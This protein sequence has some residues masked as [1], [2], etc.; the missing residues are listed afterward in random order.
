MLH[1]VVHLSGWKYQISTRKSNS[2]TANFHLTRSVPQLIYISCSS[3]CQIVD[4]TMQFIVEFSENFCNSL[5]E[6]R[7]Q[8][9][10]AH[11][12]NKHLPRV[13]APSSAPIDHRCHSG[14]PFLPFLTSLLTHCQLTW[15]IIRWAM[16]CPYFTAAVHGLHSPH[17]THYIT[18][19]KRFA[20]TGPDQTN[21]GELKCL[22]ETCMIWI[23]F[24]C[25][26]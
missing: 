12:H 26:Q 21:G 25:K 9:P 16:L 14:L 10:V 3:F 4:K 13:C 2:H 22:N 6:C 7:T 8:W 5:F 15:W 20:H 24:E 23:K 11:W 18:M 1:R 17:T 19:Y